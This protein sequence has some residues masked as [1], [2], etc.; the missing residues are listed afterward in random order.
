MAPS[1]ED[2]ME[3]CKMVAKE[4]EMKVTVSE[5][6]KGSLLALGGAFF[7]GLLGGKT[8]LAIGGSL[9]AIAGASVVDDFR[10]VVDVIDDMNPRR[11]QELY[12]QA[13]RVMM[14]FDQSDVAS[15][16]MMLTV[17]DVFRAKLVTC[18]KMFVEG[19]LNMNVLA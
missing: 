13:M 18:I 8:G 14:S 11:K 19:K 3:L 5:A 4:E 6:A 15:A 16:V 1:I 10:S 17:S 2:V 9:G 12:N 7:G